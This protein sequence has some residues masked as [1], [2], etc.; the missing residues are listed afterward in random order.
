MCLTV[1]NY[2]IDSLV[3]ASK[4]IMLPIKTDYVAPSLERNREEDIQKRATDKELMGLHHKEIDA[5]QPMM[6][7]AKIIM[8]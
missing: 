2:R 8:V 3:G 7:A 5:G 4:L 6:Y 1:D